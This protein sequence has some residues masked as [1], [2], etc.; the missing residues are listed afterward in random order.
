MP[1]NERTR[2]LHNSD[3]DAPVLY[4]IRNERDARAAFAAF[5][6]DEQE[7]RTAAAA[8]VKLGGQL[9]GR[10]AS[11]TERYGLHQRLYERIVRD[12]VTNRER[13]QDEKASVLLRTLHEMREQNLVIQSSPT[14]HRA[15][16]EIDIYNPSTDDLRE[17]FTV[18][19]GRTRAEHAGLLNQTNQEARDLFERGATVYG[20]TLIIP[21]LSEGAPDHNEQIRIGSL[22]HAVGE[23]APLVGEDEAKVRAAEFVEL[24]S[25]IAGVTADGDTRLVTFRAFYQEIKR[26]EDGRYR[27]REEQAAQI[28]PVLQ[29][30]RVLAAA[31]REQE[32]QR[33]PQELISFEDWERGFEAR[34]RDAESEKYGRL[35]Y[36]L[37]ESLEHDLDDERAARERDEIISRAEERAVPGG[38]SAYVEY[39]RIRLD[40]LPPRL[41]EGLTEKAEARL[42]YEVI[43]L[44]DRQLESG[45]TTSNILR[46]LAVQA[47]KEERRARET[48]IANILLERVPA[49]NLEHTVTREEEARALYTLRALAAFWSQSEESDAFNRALDQ[50][51]AGRNFTERERAAAIDTVGARLAQDYRDQIARLNAFDSLEAERERLLEEDNEFRRTKRGTPEFQQLLA[52]AR[53]QEREGRISEHEVLIRSNNASLSTREKVPSGRQSSPSSQPTHATSTNYPELIGEPRKPSEYASLHRANERSRRDLRGQLE[54]LLTKPDIEL[55]L[56]Q[57]AAHIAETARRFLR[58]TGREIEGASEAREALRPKLSRMR[59]TLD[60]LATERFAIGVERT[61]PVGERQPNPLYVSLSANGGPRLAVENLN[62]YRTVVSV[63]EKY[64][65]GIHSYIGLY[66][67]EITGSSVAQE[68]VLSF[69]RDY[70]GYRLSDDTTRM[71]NGH[72]LFREFSSRLSSARSLAKLRETIKE[73]RQENYARAKYPERFADEIGAAQRRGEQ[74]RRPLTEREMRQLMLAP[75]PAHFTGDMRALLL[76]YSG[77]ARDKAQRIKGLERGTLAPSPALTLLLAEFDRTR[78]DNPIQYARNIKAYLADYLNPPAPN[79][80]RFS[81]HNLFELREKLS[82]AERDYFFKVVDGTKQAVISGEKVKQLELGQVPVIGLGG[83]SG[84]GENPSASRANGHGLND[85]REQLEER[86][87]SYLISVVHTRGVQSL[88]S[89][90]ESLHHAKMVSR[91]I[92]ETFAEK[93]YELEDFRLNQERVATVVGKLVGELPR[94]LHASRDRTFGHEFKLGRSAHHPPE[95]EYRAQRARNDQVIE[96]ELD[97]SLDDR[98]VEQKVSRTLGL[99]TEQGIRRES[100]HVEA[101]GHNGDRQSAVQDIAANGREHSLRQHVL[102]K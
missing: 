20:E 53:G 39:E 42:R 24:G 33:E 9:A 47:E 23:F 1:R 66:G 7:L 88:E 61:R 95:H 82:P 49:A 72:R 96:A 44:L 14:A 83:R 12:P 98:V 43:P 60:R 78:S 55:K 91:I 79:Q 93:G 86:V 80:Y 16:I 100:T 30:M 18:P 74:V 65:I 21:R 13:T 94:A 70:V 63:A 89:S 54:R 69:A 37:E 34:Q 27:T 25:Q 41:P 26:D 99:L 48:E 50:E 64:G 101:A 73:I 97:R 102:V 5:L 32:W 85:L 45:A 59:A 4:E 90:R 35:T 19:E 81:L 92:E 51:I 11:R 62:E 6:G 84:T 46:G 36:R 8:F 68:K 3:K 28:E 29:R 10:A 15:H 58:L 56:E 67:R 2:A 17:T 38:A 76:E 40:N 57:N 22:S 87:A 75:A 52:H 71:L 77:S 31:M